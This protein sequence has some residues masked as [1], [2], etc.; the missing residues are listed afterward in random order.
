MENYDISLLRQYDGLCYDTMLFIS[1]SFVEKLLTVRNV[2]LARNQQFCTTL[3]LVDFA[4]AF[5]TTTG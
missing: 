2:I 5:D 3:S 4:K 1:V